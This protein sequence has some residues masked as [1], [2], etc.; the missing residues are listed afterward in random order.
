[1]ATP[2]SPYEYQGFVVVGRFRDLPPALLS[3]SILDSAAV[4]C[5]LADEHAIRMDW[6]WSNLL[7]GVKLCVKKADA[8]SA[9]SLLGQGVP[10]KFDVEAVGEYQQPRCPQCQSLQVSFQGLNKAVDY[11]RALLGGHLPYSRSLWE[12]DSCGYQWPESNE[13]PPANFLASASSVLLIVLTIGTILTWVIA[14]VFS[15]TSR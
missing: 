9:A 2:D 8:D 14:A 5:F 6:F 10:E 13:K 4:D 11:T 3:K 15:F 12:C 7:G 1:M